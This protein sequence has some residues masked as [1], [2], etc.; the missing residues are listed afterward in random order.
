MLA[1]NKSMEGSSMQETQ[2]EKFFAWV[3]NMPSVGSESWKYGLVLMGFLAQYLLDRQMEEKGSKPFWKNLEDLRVR[4]EYVLKL[5]PALKQGLEE[6]EA[7]DQPLVRKAFG[8]I[9]YALL[10]STQPKASVK[11]LNFYIA[12]GMGLYERYRE[13]VREEEGFDDLT[14]L[15]GDLG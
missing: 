14:I 12:S 1:Y 5:L 11:E 10:Q 15:F 6:I 4:W 8:E 2:S 9:S 7:F 13:L 3:R